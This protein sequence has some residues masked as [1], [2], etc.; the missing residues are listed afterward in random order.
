[1]AIFNF[2]TKPISR[3][4]WPTVVKAAAY[5]SGEKFKSYKEEKVYN[6][7]GRRDVLFRKIMAPPGA[8]EWANDGESLWNNVDRVEARWNARLARGFQI[9]LPCEL[10]LGQNI[11]LVENFCMELVR[12]GAV[13]HYGIHGAKMKSDQRNTHVHIMATTREISAEGFGEKIKEWNDKASLYRWRQLWQDLTN[14]ALEKAGLDCRVDCRSHASKGLDLEPMIHLGFKDMA[15]ERAGLQSERGNINR[16]IMARNE[17]RLKQTIA[18]VMELNDT[19]NAAQQA[20]DHEK[21]VTELLRDSIKI[22][23]D[24]LKESGT[25]PRDSLSVI[26]T[27]DKLQDTLNPT[28]LICET[29]LAQMKC[30]IKNSTDDSEQN[31]LE[32]LR[33]LT[34]NEVVTIEECKNQ[35]D[36]L[37]TTNEQRLLKLEAQLDDLIDSGLEARLRLQIQIESSEFI[38]LSNRIQA[39]ILQIIDNKK[40]A[41]DI[42]ACHHRARVAGK[43]YKKHISEWN[44]RAVRDIRYAP[45]DLTFINLVAKTRGRES[46]KWSEFKARAKANQWDPLRIEKESRRIQTRLDYELARAFGLEKTYSMSR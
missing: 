32:L 12:Q 19:E 45:T 25:P 28:E 33:K 10:V 39:A 38:Q 16:E 1:M 29:H 3:R 2:L 27:L 37:S 42:A 18:P 44:R 13:A 36:Q 15:I 14:S 9:A 7:A 4:K 46:S 40:H 21:Q 24:P 35:L 20:A 31:W 26:D 5:I 8:P 23:L 30:Q 43:E 22:G 41:G 34:N 17:I 11:E 6:Y